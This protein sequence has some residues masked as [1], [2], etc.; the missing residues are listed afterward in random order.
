M[1]RTDSI[2]AY[3]RNGIVNAAPTN[4]SGE[5]KAVILTL[6]E[7]VVG[8]SGKSAA[9]IAWARLSSHFVVRLSRLTGHC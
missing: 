9:I 3:D 2:G 4:R 6:G 1:L 5:P 8:T 7:R